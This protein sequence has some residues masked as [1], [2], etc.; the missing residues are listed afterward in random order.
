[1][2]RQASRCYPSDNS[3]RLRNVWGLRISDSR[4]CAVL[5]RRFPS[6]RDDAAR[7]V[8]RSKS[9]R[10]TDDRLCGAGERTAPS[11]GH[12]TSPEF[13]REDS[14]PVLVVSTP[15]HSGCFGP[16]HP[17]RPPV[18]PSHPA[19]SRQARPGEDSRHDS[20]GREENRS[21]TKMLKTSSLPRRIAFLTITQLRRCVGPKCATFSKIVGR[22]VTRMQ[23]LS[24][25]QEN[26]KYLKFDE[27]SES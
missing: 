27:F 26:V 25:D 5:R 13:V 23:D 2:I 6:S 16:R 4:K 24:A 1:M 19:Q 17:I 22:Q 12:H 20:M 18:E 3:P 14:S 9:C 21:S 8:L 11:T 10:M 7:T 15:G